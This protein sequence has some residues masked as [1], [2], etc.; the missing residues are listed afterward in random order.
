MLRTTKN[1]K[2]KYE[3]IQN[4]IFNMI[5]EKW[6][7]IF[8]YASVTDRTGNVQ[9]GELFFYY[10]PKS[11]LKRKPVNVYEVPAKFNIDEAE[12]TILV[13]NLYESIK[14]LRQDFADTDQD[15]WTNLTISIENARFKIEYKFDELKQDEYSNYVHHVIWRYLYLGIGGEI[16]EEKKILD[17]YFSENK[18]ERIEEYQTGLYMKTS[19]NTIGFGRVEDETEK[20]QEDIDGLEY[21]QKREIKER[22][23][24]K[25]YSP[26]GNV[27]NGKLEKN[28]NRIFKNKK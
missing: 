15:I 14:A 6:D 3:K 7:K 25:K 19:N 28:N 5:P 13:D 24:Q 21:K 1:M 12:Y 27:K 10:F 20:I 2:D 8:L 17:K 18:K 23:S 9:T 11:I 4:Q 16:K 26:L 22:A